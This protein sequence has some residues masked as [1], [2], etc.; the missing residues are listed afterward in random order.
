MGVYEVEKEGNQ[1]GNRADAA[2]SLSWK[3]FHTWALSGT[4]HARACIVWAGT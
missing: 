4:G 3:D 2:A 1:T